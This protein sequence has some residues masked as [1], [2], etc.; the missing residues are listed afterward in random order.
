MSVAN[1]IINQFLL[2]LILQDMFYQPYA[3]QPLPW[4]NVLLAFADNFM[5]K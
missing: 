2:Y 5:Q 3:C 1:I 4:Y